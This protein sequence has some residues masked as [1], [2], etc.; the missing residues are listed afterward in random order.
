[1]RFTTLL[2]VLATSLP[3]WGQEELTVAEINR[4]SEFIEAKQDALLGKV[5]EAVTLF[6]K[7]AK[8]D[9]NDDAVQFELGRLYKAQGKPDAAIDALRKAYASRPN[10]V[11]ASLLA[12]LYQ[13]TGRHK[14]GAA[15]FAQ[16]RRQKPDDEDLY[17]EEAAALVRAQDIKAAIAVY[18]A[19]EERIGVNEETTRLKHAL[20]L[21]T[22]DTKKAEKELLQL[23]E[24][25]PEITDYRHLL[26]GFYT[27]QGDVKG[28][29]KTYRAILSV[30]PADVR[31]Q[32]AL[33]KVGEAQGG[34]AMEIDGQLMDL[35]GRSDVDI[36]LKIG[37][38][39]PLVQA[40]AQSEG[41]SDKARQALRLAEE[42]QRVHPDEAKASALLGDVY[43]HSGDYVKAAE[44]YGVTLDLDDN[45]FPVWEQLLGTL[46]LS[47]QIAELRDYA[48]R[49]LDLYPNRPSIYVNYA[50]GEALRANYGEA[51]S[52][53]GE[54][55]L[56]VSTQPDATKGLRAIAE[57]V[58]LLEKGDKVAAN[59]LAGLP[60]GVDG[61]LG[62]LLGQQ[63]D[64]DILE[65]YNAPENTNALLLER[66]GDERMTAGDNT[67]AEKAY[68]RAKQAGSKSKTLAAKLT[69][70][71]NG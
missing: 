66:L 70:A 54:A 32:L 65:G 11:Y 59:K 21:G 44:A 41:G 13:E 60:G 2:I 62:V 8:A 55:Q 42:L 1:M 18:N 49:A 52:L 47:N 39:L 22:G 58:D 37:K 6:E 19:L 20:Y 36:D 63:T 68:T 27:G 16:L 14:D 61:P 7:L 26:A 67:A 48:E 71:G 4:Q 50:L 12:G 51:K 57:A 53:L 3:T 33:Q 64:I 28:A 5:D 45:V 24:A 69:K 56:M 31:A 23:I 40:I 43:F 34:Q 29:E 46:Y 17:L 30:E 38:V 9:G 35:L 25:R 10:E 15:L